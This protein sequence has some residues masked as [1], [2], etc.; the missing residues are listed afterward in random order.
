MRNF[1]NRSPDFMKF[2]WLTY[3]QPSIDYCSQLYSPNSGPQLMKLE[4][5]LRSFTKRIDGF[6]TL[7][8]WDRLKALNI[9]S[10]GRRFQR[11]KCIYIWKILNGHAQNCGIE[12]Y[13]NNKS[14]T[15][16]KTRKI[17]TYFQPQR[18]NSFQWIAPRLFNSLPRNIRDCRDSQEIFKSKLNEFLSKLPDCPLTR[19]LTPIPMDPFDCSPSNSII[20]WICYLK[21]GDRR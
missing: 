21:L 8:Y 19:E 20:H 2:L 16:C 7:N 6:H 10:V 14:G 5:I 18:A 17:G 3:L 9:S 11:Y 13:H 15:M 4:N 12:W 1:I